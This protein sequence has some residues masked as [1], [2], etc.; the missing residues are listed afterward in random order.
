[1]GVSEDPSHIST[2]VKMDF[3][4]QY[5]GL[6][7]FQLQCSSKHFMM[8]RAVLSVCYMFSRVLFNILKTWSYYAISSTCSKSLIL[9]FACAVE[10]LKYTPIIIELC[11]SF[12]DFLRFYFLRIS[13]E[14]L[15]PSHVKSDLKY[16]LLI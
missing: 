10:A 3:F 11:N 15:S 8:L 5:I 4:M 16:T 1:M 6:C 9:V 14:F 7:M 13:R 2:T 12:I